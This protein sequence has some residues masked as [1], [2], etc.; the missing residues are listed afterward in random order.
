MVEEGL[1]IQSSSKAKV[2]MWLTKQGLILVLVHD[3]VFLCFM[4]FIYVF[5]PCYYF[6][7]SRNF[8]DRDNFD[9]K[10]L[11]FMIFYFLSLFLQILL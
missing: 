11:I 10:L 4:L 6:F 1:E 7:V 9:F 8:V 2:Y 5:E 3:F